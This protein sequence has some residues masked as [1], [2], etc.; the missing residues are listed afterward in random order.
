MAKLGGLELVALTDHNTARNCPAAAAAAKE[1]GIGFIPG[2]E[3]T[4]S[5]D[6]HMVCLFPEVDAA[7]RFG[8]RIC[9][10]LPPVQNRPDIFGNQRVIGVGGEPAGTEDKLL[11]NASGFSLDELPVLCAEYGGLCYPAHVDR[12]ANGLLA[13]LGL[14]P[15]GLEVRAAEVHGE[16]V[17]EGVPGHLKIIRASDAH[18]LLDLS[19]E[20]FPLPLGSADFQGLR[21]WLWKK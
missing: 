21:D 10:S 8:E 19:A 17:P 7:V 9:Q 5:E 1:Y 4:T 6:V 12:E 3:V 13:V 16:T 18:N 2:V 15:E 14:W 20:G 11:I